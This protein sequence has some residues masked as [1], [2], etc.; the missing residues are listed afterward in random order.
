M[1]PTSNRS[2]THEFKVMLNDQEDQLLKDL[3]KDTGLSRSEVIRSFINGKSIRGYPEGFSRSRFGKTI[4]KV[5][6]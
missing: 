1:A 2:R 5:G 6:K 3:A 4:R